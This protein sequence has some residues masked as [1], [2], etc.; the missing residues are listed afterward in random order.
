V[1]APPADR[2]AVF[3][4]R[5]GKLLLLYRK[6]AGRVYDAVPGGTVE[7]GESPTQAAV[8]EIREETGLAVKVHGPVLTLQN[9]DR[10]E[11][12][13]DAWEVKG[14]AVL[15]GEE[16]ERNSARNR[17]VLMWIELEALSRRPIMPPELREWMATR[18]WSGL[19]D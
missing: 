5:D 14:E 10:T 1:T 18:D 4:R 12:Y 13:F 15:G 7:P 2:A 11:Y 6:K 8:R 19:G 17:Y 3:I 9:Q 16:A